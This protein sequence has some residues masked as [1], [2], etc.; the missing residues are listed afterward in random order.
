MYNVCL[1]ELEENDSQHCSTM[2]TP[3]RGLKGFFYALVLILVL[4]KISI[5]LSFN[6]GYYCY[7][8]KI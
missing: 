1:H 2:G 4:V 7:A 5:L 6:P 8:Q 3:I